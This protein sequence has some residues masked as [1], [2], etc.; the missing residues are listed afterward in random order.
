MSSIGERIKKIRMQL[1]KS[2]YEVADALGISRPRYA[3]YEQGRSEPDIEMLKKIARYF[4]VSVEYLIYGVESSNKEESILGSSDVEPT[5][6]IPVIGVIRGGEPIY[7][8]EDIL[9]YLHAPSSKIQN[10][11]DYF[12]LRVIGDS[13]RG[14]GIFPGSYVLVRKQDYVE[15]GD[16]AVVFIHDTEEATVKRVRFIDRRVFLFP[17]NPDYQVQVYRPE[18]VRIIG[19]VI[20]VIHAPG[21]ENNRIDEPIENDHEMFYNELLSLFRRTKNLSNEEREQVRILLRSVIDFVDRVTKR[22]A[23]GGTESTGQG[24]E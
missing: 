24:G 10:G 13:M 17:S 8:Q 7:A 4:G 18:E 1:G 2:Q 22:R 12:Y 9:G 20:M 21:G 14:D 3:H 23:D 19:K 5:R 6:L 11:Y 15:D 16:I